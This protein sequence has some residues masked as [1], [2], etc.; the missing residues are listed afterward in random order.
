M[1]FGIFVELSNVTTISSGTRSSLLA[2][3]SG[4]HSLFA[5]TP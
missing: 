3:P 2:S 5:P 4:S 1:T